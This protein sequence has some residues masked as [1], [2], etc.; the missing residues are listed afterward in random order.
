MAAGDGGG[1]GGDGG[2]FQDGAP[3]S[4]GDEYDD[5]EERGPR[6]RP[7]RAAP[8]GIGPVCDGIGSWFGDS[9]LDA[10]RP[11]GPKVFAAED[12]QIW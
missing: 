12:V 2:V 11:L 1:G 4:L 3:A 6:G 7:R 8:G 5:R 10:T 9:V